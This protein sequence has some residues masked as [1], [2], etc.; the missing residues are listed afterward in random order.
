[1]RHCQFFLFNIVRSTFLNM[2]GEEWNCIFVSF[3]SSIND[4][5]W[6][7]LIPNPYQ[8][9]EEEKG[10]K[11]FLKRI[12]SWAKVSSRQVS[13]LGFLVCLLEIFVSLFDIVTSVHQDKAR[14]R[15]C[16]FWGICAFIF[17]WNLT[18]TSFVLYIIKEMWTNTLARQEF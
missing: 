10:S 15:K 8:N 5:R 14:A 1:M 6:C 2:R 18:A 17:L 16:V 4:E 7:N 12:W 11:Q 13:I 9:Y 3:I